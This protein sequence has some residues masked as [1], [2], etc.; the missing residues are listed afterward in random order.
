MA[1]WIRRA[2]A[3]RE[4]L[5]SALHD[6]RYACV[7]ARRCNRGRFDAATVVAALHSERARAFLPV[8]QGGSRPFNVVLVPTAASRKSLDGPPGDGNQNAE[9]RGPVLEQGCFRF[10]RIAMTSFGFLILFRVVPRPKVVQC[11]TAHS[12]APKYSRMI[13]G[14]VSN[15]MACI[16][17]F[18]TSAEAGRQHIAFDRHGARTIGRLVGGLARRSAAEARRAAL[19]GGGGGG[20]SS[21]RATHTASNTHRERERSELSVAVEKKS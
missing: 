1:G 2:S 19:I 12:V 5:G 21:T 13:Y 3:G 17:L 7:R 4:T 16:C 18:P 8:A 6:A 14:W 15:R 10:Q 11:T 9:G 20:A